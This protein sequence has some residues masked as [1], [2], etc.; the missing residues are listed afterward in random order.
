MVP[1]ILRVGHTRYLSLWWDFCYV[2]WFRAAFSFS[3]DTLF[4]FYF[5][6]R[7]F[8]GV[9]LQ[10]FQVFLSF[11][12]SDRSDFSW[13]D[14]SIPSV[15]CRFLLF[16]IGMAHFSMPNRYLQNTNMNTIINTYQYINI[17]NI[18]FLSI[19]FFL[20]MVLINTKDVYLHVWI[21]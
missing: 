9:R 16:I 10:Y 8:D 2:I 15:I 7:L 4:K 11:L 17:F 13:F 18:M 14:S 19:Q 12:F 1:R 20:F 3:W 21:W 5:H 6:F